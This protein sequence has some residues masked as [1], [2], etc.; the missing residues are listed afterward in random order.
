MTLGRR[1]TIVSIAAVAIAG[2]GA[3]TS[4]NGNE[5]SDDDT[6]NSDSDSSSTS[7]S[8]TSDPV[9]EFQPPTDAEAFPAHGTL[10]DVTEIETRSQFL[11]VLE[12]HDVNVR[13]WNHEPGTLMG[14]YIDVDEEPQSVD[15]VAY[16]LSLIS[17]A[18]AGWMLHNGDLKPPSEWTPDDMDGDDDERYPANLIEV[19]M[20]LDGQDDRV[21]WIE[22][23]EDPLLDYLTGE[24]T[25]E[26][27]H[28]EVAEGAAVPA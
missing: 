14:L 27:Y 8:A 17:K 16:E 6:S 13:D 2:C 23:R 5:S 21:G 28:N 24:I 12:G 22:L 25:A 4:S 11:E 18:W 20:H 10:D 9:A 15:A 26:E 7:G 3:D 19:N 1:E